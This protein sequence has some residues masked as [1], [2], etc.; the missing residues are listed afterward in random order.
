MWNKRGGSLPLLY[1]PSI[2]ISPPSHTLWLLQ[3]ESVHSSSF[4]YCILY[5]CSLLTSYVRFSSPSAVPNANGWA[6]K[7]GGADPPP[8]PGERESVFRGKVIPTQAK[9]LLAAVA[10]LRSCLDAYRYKTHQMTHS[11]R[12]IPPQDAANCSNQ[13][14]IHNSQT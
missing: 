5:G 4:R 14:M 2:M 13:H 1:L 12:G 9:N 11:R 7:R 6:L 8:C 3:H 10:E